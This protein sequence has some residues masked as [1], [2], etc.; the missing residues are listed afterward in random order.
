MID[1]PLGS[2]LV[3]RKF[4]KVEDCQQL[5]AT[6]V[7][8]GCF[9]EEILIRERSFSRK[10]LLK[11]LENEYFLPAADLEDPPYDPTLLSKVPRRL[12]AKLLVFPVGMED[13]TI[14]VALFHPDEKA[15]KGISATIHRSL[16]CLVALRHDLRNAIERHYGRMER[17]C[18]A[19]E[20]K[21]GGAVEQASANRPQAGIGAAIQLSFKKGDPEAAIKL[22]D[23]IIEKAAKL[24]ATDI[25]LESK[26]K[27]MVLRF[28]LDGVL[29]KA[30]ALPGDMS[31]SLI[32]RIK[33]LGGMDISERRLPQ[34]G[35]H[36][37]RKGEILFDLRISS[38]PSQ[39]GEKIVI[40]LLSKN[41]G[42]LELDNLGMPP[43]VREGYGEAVKSSQGLYLVTG[44]TGSGKTTTLYATLNALDCGSVNVVTLE[45]PIEYTLP[46]ITQVQVHEEIGLTFAAGLRSFLRQDPDV[47]LI[48]EMRDAETVTIACRAS[49]TGHKVF[50]TL[51]T[52]DAAEAI[53][54]LMDMGVPPYMIANTL[55]GV[56]AQRLIR[57]LCQ[58]CKEAYV[59][60]QTELAILG[61]ARIER[62]YRAQGCPRCSHTGYNG[63]M[64]IY[65]YLPISENIHKLVYDHASS[66]AVRYAARQNGMIPL[67]EFAKWAV[68]NGTT[69]VAEIQRT[70]LSEQGRE[71]ICRHCGQVVSLDFLVCPFCKKVLKEKCV[72]C[73]HPLESTWEVCPNCG[74]EIE[75][76]M[77]KT[78]CPHCQA[79]VDSKR[80]S[81]PFCGGGI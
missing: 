40:R 47:I 10:E 26:E 5:L 64:A 7:S 67:S 71:Q 80:E 75:S 9:L 14:T 65:E 35:R 6:A 77:R 60:N 46:G 43:A 62:I 11:I 21:D 52:N 50:S 54:R 19:L 36:T 45:D 69:S 49:L 70:V 4:L 18:S 78:Y 74:A 32:S 42:L 28:R 66:F 12:A 27:E 63:R 41:L 53:P 58:H 30:A 68:L 61:Y 3:E 37:I 13:Q 23:E 57:V 22:T 76:E 34:D 81:C 16:R 33:I 48:G 79:P 56:L 55:K 8:E 20:H 1:D 59:P 31:A 72:K 39:F 15:R 17:E 24:S 2:I 29:Y 38:I 25:H 73:D 44:P 51:H